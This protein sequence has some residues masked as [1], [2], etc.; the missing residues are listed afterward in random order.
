MVLTGLVKTIALVLVV[1]GVGAIIV[2]AAGIFR[3]L[4]MV[5]K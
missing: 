2:T 1:I 3:D 5:V 4:L